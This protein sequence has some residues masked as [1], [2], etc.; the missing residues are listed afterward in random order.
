MWLVFETGG[1]DRSGDKLTEPD[2]GRFGPV[3]KIP[4]MCPGSNTAATT[5][6]GTLGLVNEPCFTKA[7]P[8]PDRSARMGSTC[9]NTRCGRPVRDRAKNTPA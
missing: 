3:V 4:L 6:G 7:R 5:G 9:R 1:K 2:Y 8:A